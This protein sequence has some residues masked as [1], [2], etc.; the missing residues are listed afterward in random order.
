MSKKVENEVSNPHYDPIRDIQAVDQVGA[1]DLRQANAMNS[2]PAN[3][4]AEVGSSNDI[5]DP[6]SIGY[7]PK[8]Q[9]EAAQA[10]RATADYVPP[11]KEE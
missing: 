5:D 7:R 3:L 4:E 8:D 10:A 1:V 11:K 9:F 6:R 2:I